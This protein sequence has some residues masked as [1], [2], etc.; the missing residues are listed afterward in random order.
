MTHSH[1]TQ[2]KR[3]HARQVRVR[4]HRERARRGRLARRARRARARRVRWHRA[5]WWY[6][7]PL[8]FVALHRDIAGEYEQFR[9]F[10]VGNAVLSAESWTSPRPVPSGG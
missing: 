5:P 6:R 9:R 3:S 10:Q 8:Q 7:H 4:A 2:R 1:T